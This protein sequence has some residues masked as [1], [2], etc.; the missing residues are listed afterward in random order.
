M[1][2][3]NACMYT[4]FGLAMLYNFRVLL[5]NRNALHRGSLI[6]PCQSGKGHFNSTVSAI[7]VYALL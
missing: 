7:Y 5:S 1:F 6:E 3:L 2:D 4:S